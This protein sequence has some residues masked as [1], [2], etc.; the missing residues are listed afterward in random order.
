M[1][2]PSADRGRMKD[3][4]DG[5]QQSGSGAYQHPGGGSRPG[6]PRRPGR[7]GMRRRRRPMFFRRPMYRRPMRR[8]RFRGRMHYGN[9]NQI[10]GLIMQIAMANPQVIPQLL[11]ALRQAG[12]RCPMLS[13]MNM[14]GHGG[15]GMGGDYGNKADNYSGGSGGGSG[16]YGGSGGG[17]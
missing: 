7:P 12:I 10:C 17:Y 3:R 9:D 14:G 16:G 13:I 15:R 4:A 2:S 5:Q 8:F 6:Y 11:V 1:S